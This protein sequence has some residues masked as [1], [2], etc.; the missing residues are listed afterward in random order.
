MKGIL[1][2]LI[3]ISAMILLSAC[4]QSGFQA[5]P[6]G[7]ILSSAL[8]VPTD[9]NLPPDSSARNPL[10]DQEVLLAHKGYVSGGGSDSTLVVSIDVE[11]QALLVNVPLA[12]PYLT[13]GDSSGSLKDL[14]GASFITSTN[15]Q[16]NSEVM[17]SVPLKY[18]VKGASFLRSSRLPNGDLLPSIPSGELPSLAIALPQKPD[19]QLHIYVGVGVVA[20]FVATPMDPVIPMTF[21]IKDENKTKIIG[22]LSTIPEKNGF[23]GGFLLTTVLPNEV[24]VLLEQLL[25]N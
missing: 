25:Q 1:N 5:A 19:F 23:N 22:S 16:G 9:S 2:N 11:N 3:K 8:D 10:S 12:L 4:S 7:E 24:A 15:S 6:Q 14:P 17:L 13:L 21:H 18:L 20:I